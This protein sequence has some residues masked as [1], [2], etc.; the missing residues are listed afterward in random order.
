MRGEAAA[1]GKRRQKLWADGAMTLFF[2][3]LTTLFLSLFLVLAES[4]RYQGARARAAQT[5]DMGALSV[6]GEYEKALLDYEIFG[7]NGAYG[8]GDFSVGRVEDR[9]WQF[10]QLNASPSAEG[11][12]SLCFDPWQLAL[13]D[14]RITGYTLLSDRGGEYFYQQAVSCMR[15]TAVTASIGMLIDFYM[16]AQDAQ[17]AAE[18]YEQAQ[19]GSDDAM[20]DL[21]LK[22]EEVRKEQA[23]QEAET[24]QGTA[25]QQEKVKNPLDA[26]DRLRRKGLLQIVCQ[27][28]P[29]SDKSVSGS[30]LWSKRWGGCRG[31]LRLD[32]KY[33]S[34][35]DN[36]LY[37]EY[38]LNRLPYY[39]SE[40]KKKSA[41]SLDYQIEYVLS[42]KKSDRA[43]LKAAV[44]K[45]LLLREGC[46]YAYSTGDASLSAR[47]EGMAALVIGWTG[48]PE[49][50]SI[51]KHALL[52]GISYAESLMD[53]RILLDGGRVP[54]Y[55]DAGSWK[56]SFENLY[57]IN[58]IL[59]QGGKKNSDGLRYRDYLR[60]LLNLQGVGAQKKRGLDMIEL[61]VAAVEGQSNFRADHCL[62][63]L[64]MSVDWTIAPVFDAVSGIWLGQQSA[65]QLLTLTGGFSYF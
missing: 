37:R 8:T 40:K 30:S 18:Q 16:D 49:L 33:G 51:L 36:L 48:I 13:R 29:V 32:T 57:Q 3:L 31:N 58:E 20:E 1:D 63:G 52:L 23:Q 47:A 10:L 45:L 61:N 35:T 41:A 28:N 9:L 50:V 24:G 7:L 22:E 60:L 38:L 56:I 4:A 34:L 53:V 65:P 55:K 59:Q 43:N 21:S 11:L 5:V 2:T 17:S 42:G 44:Q 14:V 25:A 27:E 64:K 62:V 12:P 39:G 54:L 46:N 6:F 15:E 26:L 19:S